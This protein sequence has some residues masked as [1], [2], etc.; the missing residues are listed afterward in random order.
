MTLYFSCDSPCGR[1]SFCLN[2]AVN[3]A[4]VRKRFKKVSCCRLAKASFLPIS[5]ASPS[6][7]LW[8]VFGILN[9][10]V[11][12]YILSS[13]KKVGR[14]LGWAAAVLYSCRESVLT[15]L[16]RGRVCGLELIEPR[17]YFEPGVLVLRDHSRHSRFRFTVLT[18]RSQIGPLVRIQAMVVEFL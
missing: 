9:I 15:A 4:W 18:K 14:E 10:Y 12:T 6:V 1:K 5:P 13:A 16:G 17:L 2:S 7:L 11:A 3:T 8:V